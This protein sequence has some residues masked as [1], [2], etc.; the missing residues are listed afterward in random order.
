[1]QALRFITEPSNCRLVIDLPRGLDHGL[2]EVIVMPA[3]EIPSKPA[4]SV[5]T[6]LHGSVIM[7]DDLIVP[8]PEDDWDALK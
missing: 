1:M 6:A 4:R 7:R 5:P 8:L 3:P 2:L